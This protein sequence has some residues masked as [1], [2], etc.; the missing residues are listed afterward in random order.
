MWNN[1]FNIELGGYTPPAEDSFADITPFDFN[2]FFDHHQA[3]DVH[4][5]PYSQ[6]SDLH[7]DSYSKASDLHTD[8]YCQASDLHTAPYS[9]ASDLAEPLARK[10]NGSAKPLA[11]K[12]SGLTKPSASKTIA[13]S[14]A[15]S[16]TL[17]T[18]A[19]HTFGIAKAASGRTVSLPK[20]ASRQTTELAL[21]PNNQTYGQAFRSDTTASCQTI[22][23]RAAPRAAK[24][25]IAAAGEHEN[26]SEIPPVS[27]VDSST[28]SGC[29]DNA[30]RCHRYRQNQ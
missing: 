28:S 23:G 11:R 16:K 22:T 26:W 24:P 17:G 19:R 2:Q 29:N 4:T 3:S 13:L 10:T 27:S 25:S 5:D 15:A 6:A 14:A 9:Q 12:P 18:K 7:T 8:P 30:T 21:G 20:V 1:Y